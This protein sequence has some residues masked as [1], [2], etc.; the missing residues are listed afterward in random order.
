MIKKTILASSALALAMSL[1]VQAHDDGRYLTS[2]NGQAA[3]SSNGH[4]VLTSGGMTAE[5]LKAC[6]WVAPA[7]APVAA[8]KPA[9]A[10]APAPEPEP[11]PVMEPKPDRG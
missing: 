9:P 10:P 3:V 5:E 1:N 4:C 7:P 11:E 8:P 6:G 2:S